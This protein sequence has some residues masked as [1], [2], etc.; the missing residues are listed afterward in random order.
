MTTKTSQAVRSQ[1]I[2][3]SSRP[4]GV[5]TKDNSRSRE[6]N[7]RQSVTVRYSSA[8]TQPPA[9]PRNLFKI[10][11]K[12]LRMQGFIVRDRRDDFNTF[13][14]DVSP[15]I[16]SGHIVWEETVTDM[17]RHSIVCI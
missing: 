6:L 1:Q 14:K 9:A 3:L 12:R 10:I 2:V 16:Q 5:P 4:D 11:G 13:I 17:R 15:L 8:I 7:C